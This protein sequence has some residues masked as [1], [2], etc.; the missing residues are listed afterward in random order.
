MNNSTLGYKYTD[1]LEENLSLKNQFKYFQAIVSSKTPRKEALIKV[2]VR[3]ERKLT[4]QIN[5]KAYGKALTNL[6]FGSY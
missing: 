1:G 3:S 2:H 6:E 5:N 4:L